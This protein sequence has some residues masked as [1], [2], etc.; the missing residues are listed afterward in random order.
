MAKIRAITFDL[1][2]TVFIDDTDEPKRKKQDLAPKPVARRDLVA[3]A[4]GMTS[5]AQR[6]LVNCA[7]DTADAAFY[8]VWYDQHVTWTVAERLSV[9][10]SGL[11]AKLPAEDFEALVRKH[12]EM[13]LHISPDLVPGVVEAITKLAERYKL[14]V[15]SDAIFSPGWVLKKILEK[16]DLLKHF[17]GFVFSDEA[18]VSKPKAE[19]FQRAAELAGCQVDELLHLGDREPKD[20]AGPKAVGARAVLVTAA[21]DRGTAGTRADAVCADYAE[22]LGIINKLDEN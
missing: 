21:I 13:E 8:R 16:Y 9:V 22:L 7:Y 1:W 18:G 19:L 2:D 5:A 10:L 20:I 12:E 14:L 6:A 11:G 15:I 4:L 17:S 3:D